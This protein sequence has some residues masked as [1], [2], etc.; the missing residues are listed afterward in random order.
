MRFLLFILI[1]LVLAGCRVIQANEI[2]VIQDRTT[3]EY[4]EPLRPGTHFMS[5]NWDV[6]IYS[7]AYLSF[8]FSDYEDSEI[9]AVQA[10]SLDGE[11]VE[12]EISIMFH[13][14]PLHVTTLHQRW[15]DQYVDQLLVPVTRSVVREVFATVLAD[16]SYQAA[17]ETIP[18]DIHTLLGERVATDG[19]VIDDVIIRD[20]GFSEAFAISREQTAIAKYRLTETAEAPAQLL[21]ATP[22]P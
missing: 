10:V 6:T 13:I 7:T 18:M 14:D 3:G 20:I 19:L 5:Q 21:T 1:G 16:D 12:V 11:R 2:A 22:S 9:G 8:T 17:R 15:G 4:L